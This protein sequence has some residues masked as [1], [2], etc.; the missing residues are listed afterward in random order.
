MKETINKKPI[1]EEQIQA[2]VKE[3]EEGYDVAALKKAGRG[4]PGRAALPSQVVAVRF[5]AEEIAL[6]DARAKDRH[7]TRSELIREALFA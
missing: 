6:L 5:T 7:I 4:R 3:A 1:T 2:W